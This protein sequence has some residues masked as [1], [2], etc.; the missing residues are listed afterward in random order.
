MST[1]FTIS[2]LSAEF[3]IT[4]RTIRFYEE[5]GLLAPRRKGSARIY[6][7]ADRARLKLI[8][9]GKRLGFTLD[10]SRSIIEMYDPAHGNRDQLHS[11]LTK[12]REK[13]DHL[14]QQL[15]D[16]EGMMLDLQDAEEKCLDALDGA[17]GT[18]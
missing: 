14:K 7:P 18:D 8:L 6:S 4:T 11:L 17:D 2:D 9:R 3:D 1:E 16:I 15:H 10:E 5:K 12:I 13:Q